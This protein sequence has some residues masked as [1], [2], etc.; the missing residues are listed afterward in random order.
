MGLN[1]GEAKEE[2][3]GDSPR[4]GGRRV[5]G[6]EVEPVLSNGKVKKT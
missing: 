2:R 5:G 4:E 3:C 1:K 6:C